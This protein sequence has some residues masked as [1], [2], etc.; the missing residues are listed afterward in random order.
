MPIPISVVRAITLAAA[1]A[2][3]KP[4]DQ[5]SRAP[6]A[7][8][9]PDAFAL[10]SDDTPL[11]CPCAELVPIARRP[12]FPR[13]RGTARGPALLQDECV[14]LAAASDGEGARLAL[15]VRKTSRKLAFDEAQALSDEVKILARERRAIGSNGRGAH[16]AGAEVPFFMALVT[17]RTGTERLAV[18][19]AAGETLLIEARETVSPDDETIGAPP[20][21]FDG[22]PERILALCR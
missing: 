2:A 4:S 9:G 17:R 8:G 20:A 10:L 15:S 13:V 18:A 19:H 16:P 11:L 3:C 5:R 1:F 7:M 6:L 12:A 22:L 21:Y 14:Y